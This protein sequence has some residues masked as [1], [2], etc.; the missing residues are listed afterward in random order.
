MLASARVGFTQWSGAPLSGLKQVRT[1]RKEGQPK[2]RDQ[3]FRLALSSE[4]SVPH[5]HH[6]VLPG[7][8]H[9]SKVKKLILLAY[10]I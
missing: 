4:H 8:S 6:C 2:L 5:K 7:Q 1:K 10:F 9:F 3:T